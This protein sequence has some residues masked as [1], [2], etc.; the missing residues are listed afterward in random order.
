MNALQDPE[1]TDNDESDECNEINN[2]GD[3]VHV[4]T[5]ESNLKHKMKLEYI[6]LVYMTN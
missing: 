1:N 4:I 5:H 6:L 2:I 3:I